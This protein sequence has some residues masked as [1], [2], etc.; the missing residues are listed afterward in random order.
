MLSRVFFASTA[1]PFSS[2]SLFSTGMASFS[3]HC[4][5]LPEPRIAGFKTRRMARKGARRED[6][7]RT[8]LW[9]NDTS[10]SCNRCESLSSYSACFSRYELMI[11]RRSSGSGRAVV[12]MEA[13]SALVRS[14]SDLRPSQSCAV[15]LYEILTQK[16][17]LVSSVQLL[18]SYFQ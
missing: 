12:G 11:S 13:V 2:P 9:Y 1:R 7:S 3:H 16:T 8:W 17:S 6:L 15:S 5:N 14:F 18:Q 10:S 4:N